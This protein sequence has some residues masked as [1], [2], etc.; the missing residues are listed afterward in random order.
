MHPADRVDNSAQAAREAK[1]LQQ[2]RRADFQ[3]LL[4]DEGNRRIIHA[5][6]DWSGVDATAFN[7]NAMAQSYRIGQQDSARW[8]L[9]AMRE[10]CPEKEQQIRNEARANRPAAIE[11][12]E[13]D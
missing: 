5:F 8:W 6:L 2:Q 12:D 13:N 3:R 9:D 7:T 4:S 11:E 10:H 1:R